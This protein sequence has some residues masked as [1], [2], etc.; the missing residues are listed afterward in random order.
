[1]TF[2]SPFVGG[3]VSSGVSYHPSAVTLFTYMSSQP[4]DTRKGH[5][6]TLISGLDTDGIWSK[7]TALYCFAS[8]TEQAAKLNWKTPSA[9]ELAKTGTVTHTTDV[10][11]QGN[12]TT[13]YL[14]TPYTGNNLTD[15]DHCMFVWVETNGTA[16][17]KPMIMYRSGR[18]GIIGGSTSKPRYYG[19]TSTDTGVNGSVN[20]AADQFI[21][22][23]R[24]GTTTQIRV[25]TTQQETATVATDTTNQANTIRI[26]ADQ[27]PN[28]YDGRLSFVGFGQYLDNTESDNLRTR[29]RTYLT[30]VGVLP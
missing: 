3:F 18:G 28:Y 7:L 20:S 17:L 5:I 9:T 10:G 26:F 16:V 22:G 6:S 19:I 1:M 15:T 14:A 23:K 25:E 2:P 21:I 24:T 27:V 30:A 8:H 11:Y 4:D 12:G 29:M 13:G